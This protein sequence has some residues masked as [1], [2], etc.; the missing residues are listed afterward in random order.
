MAGTDVSKTWEFCWKSCTKGWFEKLAREEP[1]LYREP[2]PGVRIHMNWFQI[3]NFFLLKTEIHKQILNT[4]HFCA[5]LG[6][7]DI[8]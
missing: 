6:G 5:I 4:N 8:C 7:W 2:A 1:A 3:F